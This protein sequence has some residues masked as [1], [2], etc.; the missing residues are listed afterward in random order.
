VFS[1]LVFYVSD[2]MLFV[3]FFAVGGENWL[4]EKEGIWL[5]WSQ[6]WNM[7]RLHIC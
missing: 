7:A 6:Y 5:V 2:Q 4:A 3:P 1:P